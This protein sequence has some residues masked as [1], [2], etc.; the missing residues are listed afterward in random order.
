MELRR[1]LSIARHRLPLIIVIVLAALLGAYLITPRQSRYSAT[2]TIYVGPKTLSLNQTGAA[3][4]AGSAT[5][6]YDRF[7]N[8]FVQMI[9]TLDIADSAQARADVPRTPKEVLSEVS[10]QQIFATNLMQITV[11]DRDPTVAKQL[12]QAVS[13]A[14]IAKANTLSQG[15]DAEAY[16][17]VLQPPVLPTTPLDNGI[18]RN[19]LIGLALGVV[20][21]GIVVALL[22]YV[23]ITIRVP[24][25]VERR[26]GLP[27]L[28]VI[29]ALGDRLPTSRTTRVQPARAS[30][31]HEPTSAPRA[32][33]HG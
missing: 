31:R 6:G 33:S 13:D 4:Q 15:N 11:T 3:A 12:S 18:I 32:A 7:I 1:Y 24:D 14:F 21:A 8:T 28:G 5:T 17:T 10:A 22:E 26:L 2:T 29:P 30:R 20:V 27:V 23:D 9:Q 19:M 16:V 25:D